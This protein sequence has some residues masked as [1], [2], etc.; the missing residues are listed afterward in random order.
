MIGSIMTPMCTEMAHCLEGGIL[1]SSAE[2]EMGLINGLGFPISR[3]AVF[4]ARCN[5]TRP[6]LRERCAILGYGLAVPADSGHEPYSGCPRILLRLTIK[7]PGR[8]VGF[9]LSP[10]TPAVSGS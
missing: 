8:R 6:V 10:P 2:T 3:G 4:L 1:A 5:R 9:A 7:A